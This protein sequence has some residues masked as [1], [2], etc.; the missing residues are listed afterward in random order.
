MHA[1]LGALAVI[2]LLAGPSPAA[3]EPNSQGSP[4]HRMSECN[5]QAGDKKLAGEARKQFMSDCL[6]GHGP[7]RDKTAPAGHPSAQTEKMK[8][9]NQEAAAKSLHGDDRK[10]FM[11]QCLKADKKS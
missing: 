10:A 11:S 8:A 2:L 5:A 9:C 4:T 3:E 1:L 6:K 7:S